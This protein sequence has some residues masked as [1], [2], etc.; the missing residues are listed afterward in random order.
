MVFRTKMEL[1]NIVALPLNI[2]CKICIKYAA[3]THKRERT[4]TYTGG[5]GKEGIH[6]RE[7]W[8]TDLTESATNWAQSLKRREL[9]LH[10]QSGV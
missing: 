10:L 2:S 8:E 5:T 3:P 9:T 4:R 1:Y 7:I 6:S